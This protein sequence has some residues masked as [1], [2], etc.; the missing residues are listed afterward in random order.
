MK[1]KVLV[2][3]GLAAV[4]VNICNLIN[5]DPVK[6]TLEPLGTYPG[7]LVP[8][9]L[10]LV[11]PGRTY[12]AAGSPALVVVGVAYATFNPVVT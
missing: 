2:S 12:T 3:P 4:L 10:T 9:P 8:E 1:V 5:C 6:V 7:L 11:D